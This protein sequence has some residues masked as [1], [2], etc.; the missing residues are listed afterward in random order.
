MPTPAS[1]TASVV[2]DGPAID[3]RGVDA[4]VHD[5]EE[6]GGRQKSSL[7]RD[8]AGGRYWI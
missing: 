5:V 8:N 3:N 2:A 1:R 7:T 6:A 4:D